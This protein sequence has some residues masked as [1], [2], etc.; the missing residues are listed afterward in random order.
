M[1]I[2][3]TFLVLI[4]VILGVVQAFKMVGLDTKFA[5]LV[6]IGLG[7]L[8]AFVLDGFTGMAVLGGIVA[9]LSSC[10]LYS[11]AKTTAKV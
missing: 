4:P 1:E 2:S 11:G 7:V 6:S 8:G 9:G 10:G 3:T 5:P